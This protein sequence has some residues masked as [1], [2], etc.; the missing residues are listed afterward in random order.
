MSQKMTVA[1]IAHRLR[2][3]REA[4]QLTPSQFADGAGIKRNTYSQWEA[5]K[6]RPQLDQA[7]ALCAKYRLT[8]DWIYFGNTDGLPMNLAREIAYAA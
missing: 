8:L 1:A 6:G 7:M 2:A 5:A 3:T 4:L